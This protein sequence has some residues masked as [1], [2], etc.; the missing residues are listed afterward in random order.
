MEAMKTLPIRLSPGRDLRAAPEAV[1]LAL[2]PDWQFT[3]K[4]DAQTGYAELVVRPRV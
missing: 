4:P 3:R 1:L 2:L